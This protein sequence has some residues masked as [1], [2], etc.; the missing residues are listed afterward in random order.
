MKICHD[1]EYPLIHSQQYYNNTLISNTYQ[2]LSNVQIPIH[3]KFIDVPHMNRAKQI[4]EITYGII[5]Y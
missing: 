1:Q 2:L 4:L 5:Y 3:F